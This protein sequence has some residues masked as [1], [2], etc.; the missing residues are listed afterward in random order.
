MTVAGDGQNTLKN[1]N[2]SVNQITTLSS[3]RKCREPTN[4]AVPLHRKMVILRLAHWLRWVY[5]CCSSYLNCY[6]RPRGT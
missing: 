3:T 4:K 1:V 5:R 6:T 2:T